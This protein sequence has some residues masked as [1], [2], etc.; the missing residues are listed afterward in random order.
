MATSVQ[1]NDPEMNQSL[2]DLVYSLNSQIKQLQSWLKC[3]HMKTTV[4]DKEQLEQIEK[5]ITSLENEVSAMDESIR[6]E[7]ESMVFVERMIECVTLHNK[8]ISNM[9]ERMP[10][11]LPIIPDHYQLPSNALSAIIQ[12]AQQQ[13]QN[14]TNKEN[15]FPM[16]TSLNISPPQQQQQQQQ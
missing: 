7:E 8:K 4:E 1:S 6:K 14:N 9:I 11:Q 10:P 3:R 2:G 12:Y 13:Q 15:I 5:R 16:S